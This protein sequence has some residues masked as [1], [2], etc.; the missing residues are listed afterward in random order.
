MP[1]TLAKKLRL[2]LE[3]EIYIIN[4]PSDDYFEGFCCIGEKPEQPVQT[5]VLFVEDLDMLVRETMSIVENDLLE[6]NGRLF[7]VY[8][9]KGNKK[10]NSFVHR[11]AIFPA[12]QVQENGYI[13]NSIYKFNQM[14]KLD[15]DFT[16][17]GLKKEPLKK[18]K[19]KASQR[20]LD[21]VEMIPTLM[22][23]LQKD[24]KAFAMYQ[25]LTLGYQKGWARYIFSAKKV[26]TQNKR[27][28]EAIVLLKQ[29]VKAIE[30]KLK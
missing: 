29:G 19:A 7:I 30:L 12:L 17:V 1:L 15:D 13:L 26:E 22:E 28:E 9:K 5:I 23:L 8:P 11:D 25:S 18:Q 2:Q 14:V 4:R 24:E 10:Y 16:I 3:D 21:Y 27:L 6:M 20:V